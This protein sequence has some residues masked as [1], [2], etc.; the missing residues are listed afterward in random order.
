[1]R[2]AL[3]GSGP[4][5]RS[6]ALGFVRTGNEVVLGSRDPSSGSARAWLDAVGEQG[7]AMDLR[8][9]ASS[10]DV[11]VFAVPGRA[12]PEVVELLAPETLAGATIIDPTNPVVISDD[13]VT[14]AF[15]ADDSAAE[16]LQRA[17]PSAHVVKAF[18]QIPAAEMGSPP[19]ETRTPLRICGDDTTAKE[20]VAALARRLGWQVRDLGPLSRART[21]ENAAVDWIRNQRANT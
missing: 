11:V 9:A 4:V 3:L 18:N 21:L 17:F 16:F 12:L 6:L 7:L 20:T 8:S 13:G 5:S 10:A 14:N 19:P 2:I 15:G 1:M